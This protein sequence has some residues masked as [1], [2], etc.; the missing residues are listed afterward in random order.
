MPPLN[1]ACTRLGAGSASPRCT[2]EAPT[3]LSEVDDAINEVVA[4]K[5]QIFEGT[6]VLSSGQFLVAVIAA[7]DAKG[8][9][10]DWDGEELAVKNTDAYN[11]Q[12]DI[13]TAAGNLRQGISTYRATCYPAAFPLNA[14]PPAAT[15]GCPSLPPSRELTCGRENSMFY[16]DVEAAIAAL[17]TDEPQLFDFKDL[18]KRTDWPRILNHDGYIQG[19]IG[20]LK[21]KGYCARWD[22]EELAVKNKSE[23]SEQFAVIY[24]HT[25]IRR[26]SGIYRVS[27]YPAAF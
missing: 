15:P 18:A 8:L 13:L 25:R 16:P 23:F 2:L 4:K 14:G 6:K 19:L 5:P 22:G 27:C 10:A 1:V 7:M 24:S 26:G 21:T 3:F 12:Y 20:I 9:C 17:L 11:D